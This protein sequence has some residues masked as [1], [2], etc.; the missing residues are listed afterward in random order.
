MT[1]RHRDRQTEWNDNKAH[2]LW[3]WCNRQMD[4]KT[5]GQMTCN[6]K[7]VLCTKVHRVVIKLN[8]TGRKVNTSYWREVKHSIAVKILS[9]VFS[10]SN[11]KQLCSLQWIVHRIASWRQFWTTSSIISCYWCTTEVHTRI[12]NDNSIKSMNHLICL[13]ITNQS[14]MQNKNIK[15]QQ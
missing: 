5:D 9:T 7:T 2:S 13:Y 6:T 14:I 8:T 12:L 1:D 10:Q 15:W 4:R 3:T 11:S